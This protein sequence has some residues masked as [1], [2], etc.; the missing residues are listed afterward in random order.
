MNFASGI[1]LKI[2]DYCGNGNIKLLS[3]FLAKHDINLNIC[4]I[5]IKKK[6]T[7]IK[8]RYENVRRMC[9]RNELC[10]ISNDEKEEFCFLKVFCLQMSCSCK[11]IE[12]CDWLYKNFE[13]NRNDI[14]T[15]DNY[16]FRRM[17][18]NGYFESYEWLHQKFNFSKEESLL[19]CKNALTIVCSNI[20]QNK[21][22]SQLKWLINTFK[23]EKNDILY[24]VNN[25]NEES[26]ENNA[27]AAICFSGN[28]E[29][30]E[31]LF[32]Q[33]KLCAE[34]IKLDNYVALRFALYNDHIKIVKFFFEHG[35]LTKEDIKI[36]TDS[37]LLDDGQIKQLYEILESCQV[38]GSLSKPVKM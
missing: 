28:F 27:F 33:F 6:E 32:F 8:K 21:T 7:H 31:W 3:N 38:F 20:F 14:I 34:D 12:L 35:G 2:I 1:V 29:V 30:F 11:N 5:N 22:F 36:V 18:M 37:D 10:F 24:D 17:F 26:I 4:R 23:Y 16:L 15:D 25:V 13:F 19:G 9:Y